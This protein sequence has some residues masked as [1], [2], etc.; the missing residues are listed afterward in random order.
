M[1]ERRVRRL[2]TFQG[3]NTAAG[4]FEPKVE[5]NKTDFYWNEKRLKAVQLLAEGVASDEEIGEQ[6]SIGRTT[7]HRWKLHPAFQAKLAEAIA[8]IEARIFSRGIARR[9]NRVKALDKRWDKLQQVIKERAASEQMQAVP[10]G[11][12]GLLVRDVKGV[13]K[14]EDFQ[15]VEL[16]AVDTGLLKELREHEKQAAQELGQWTEKQELTGKDGEPLL[17]T[18]VEIVRPAKPT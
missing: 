5:Q 4:V 14:G 10:G 2:L 6:I 1:R 13:G 18:C 15:L 17:I 16:Y 3:W 12:T 7:L 8:E 9:L 11:K